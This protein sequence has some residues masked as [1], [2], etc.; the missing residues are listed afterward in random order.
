MVDKGGCNEGIGEELEKVK[1]ME[2]QCDGVREGRPV[3]ISTG[4]GR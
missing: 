3:N 2:K 4:G 1:V